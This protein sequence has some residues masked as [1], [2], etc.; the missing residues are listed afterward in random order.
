[1]PIG[2]LKNSLYACG[3]G[4]LGL[5][6]RCDEIIQCGPDGSLETDPTIRLRQIWRGSHVIGGG[7]AT[8]ANGRPDALYLSGLKRLKP[9][10]PVTET[11]VFRTA[12]IAKLAAALLVMCLHQE[13]RLSV[14]EDV[15]AFLGYK[16]RNPLYP[17]QPIL[18]KHL[19]SH[20]SGIVD[21]PAY[22]RS[23]RQPTALDDLLRRDPQAFSAYAPGAKYQYSNLGAGTIAAMLELR[24]GR[25]FEAMMQELVFAPLG[26]TG[27]FDL[28][29][30]D[31]ERMTDIY[32]ILPAS[33]TPRFDGRA[34]IAKAKPLTEPDPQWHYTAGIG[35]LYITPRELAKLGLP[36]IEANAEGD[37]A[38]L[39]RET[40]RL[41]KTPMVRYPGDELSIW[42]CLGLM[43]YTPKGQSPLYGHQGFAYGC[44]NGLFIRDE[45][46]RGFA[47]LNSGCSEHRAERLGTIN[48]K[49]AELFL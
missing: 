32:R 21:T 4:L 24:F 6:S 43:Q 18:L 37:A 44:V 49:L 10:E 31:P 11:T 34:R 26:V 45:N 40:L 29:T 36:L 46:R 5:R 9:R 30:V 20:S 41:M 8:L 39:T 27:T 1:M 17:E 2:E 28:S 33:A 13:G 22:E 14:D 3:V 16:L 12:S 19:L 23:Y 42:H 25:S 7:V 15:S 48:R 38:F 47:S 35:N